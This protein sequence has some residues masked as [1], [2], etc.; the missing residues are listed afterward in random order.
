MKRDVGYWDTPGYQEHLNLKRY[1][2]KSPVYGHSRLTF[3][4]KMRECGITRFTEQWVYWYPNNHKFNMYYGPESHAEN[5]D[6]PAPSA[7]WPSPDGP[8]TKAM[9]GWAP[10]QLSASAG[11]Q[12]TRGGFA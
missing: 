6:F 4:N 11:R 10:A 12:G 9:S 8:A 1:S 3:K 2:R 7:G 5:P